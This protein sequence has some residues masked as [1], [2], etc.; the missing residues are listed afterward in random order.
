ML[1]LVLII[2]LSYLV[3]SIPTSIIVGKLV[4]GID[5]RN[6]GSGNPGGTNVIRVVGL[7]WGIFVI[8]FDAFKGFFATYFIAKWFYG[9]ASILNLTT[10]QIIAGCS[11]VIGHIWTIFAG[12]KGGKG[13]STSAG[14][15][16]GIAPVDLLISLMIF[17]I[18]VALT[19][20]VS[21]GSII[22]AI[23]FPF[24]IIFTEKI[25]KLEH[26]DFFTLLIFGS[27]IAVLIVYRH[28]SNIKRL[29]AGNENKLI[30]G[31]KT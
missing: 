28:R 11:A 2:A 25:L 15:L 12:F 26:S 20:Y 1:N 6:Y 18:I 14:M 8:L 4:K 27:L 16:L 21:L 24:I 30:F 22:S 10:L 7:G 23:L 29:I 17:V 9:D 31:K 13:V 19:R 5:I 3:G